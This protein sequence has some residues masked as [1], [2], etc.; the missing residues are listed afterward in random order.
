M[1]VES[2]FTEALAEAYLR[3]HEKTVRSRPPRPCPHCA[4]PMERVRTILS[5]G[6]THMRRVYDWRCADNACQRRRD[7]HALRHAF[8]R[9]ECV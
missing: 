9:G 2:Q 5:L 7:V 1:S 4:R 8:D 3:S 6:G